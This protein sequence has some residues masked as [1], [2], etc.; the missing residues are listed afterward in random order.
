MKNLDK[1]AY[2]AISDWPKVIDFNPVHKGI[3]YSLIIRFYLWDKVGRAIR[4]KQDISYNEVD[5]YLKEYKS[6]PF[7]YNPLIS[8]GKFSKS[9]FKKE[10]LIFIPFPGHLTESLISKLNKIKDFKVISKQITSQLNEKDVIKPLK[11]ELDKDWSLKL[12]KA[13]IKVLELLDIHLIFEDKQLLK[14][15]IEG[16]ISIT[17]LAEREL[18]KYKP[19]A[20]Y[21]HTDNHPPYIN[22]IL[23]AK[24]LGISTF[25]YQHGLDCEQYF[26]DDCFADYIA[27][28]SENRKNNYLA[29]SKFKPKLFQVI[30]NIFVSE[31][32]FYKNSSIEKTILFITRPHRPIKCYS[33]YRNHIEGIQILKII[34]DYMIQNKDV[35]LIIKPHPMDNVGQYECLIKFNHLEDRVVINNEKIN[36]IVS[37]CDVVITEDSTAGV[38]ALYFNVP[39]IHSHLAKSKPVLPLVEY[40]CA[41]QGSS[42]EE[43][44]NNMQKV[45]NLSADEK[46]NLKVKQLKF[47]KE[48]I[49]PG[50][51][52]DL[53]NFIINNI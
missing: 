49:P 16:A 18:V 6:F 21:V 1:I 13:V 51:K 5:D 35:N 30:G 36:T 3:D 34:F 37:K 46:K 45:F 43:I 14:E 26:L 32:K 20:L 9:I 15:Q 7:Y 47:I 24:K 10:K 19:D 28:W 22:Y 39:C 33:P 53:V 4:I 44:I 41:F 40:G 2:E 27:V 25:T 52:E 42:K 38:E 12:F 31:P 50:K 11:Y 23:A 8:K 29:N 48:F 17:K